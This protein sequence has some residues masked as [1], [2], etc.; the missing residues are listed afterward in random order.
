MS[1][2]AEYI[3]SFRTFRGISQQELGA[4]LGRT[5]NVISNWE[6]GKNDPDLDSIEMMCKVFQITPNELFGWEDNKE[7]IAYLQEK[8][9]LNLEIDRINRAKATLD[10]QLLQY[11]E[12][13]ENLKKHSN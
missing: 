4:R 2:I 12:R 5:A 7:L 11:K 1:R 13:I 8:E 9:K 6:K 10:E 3:K